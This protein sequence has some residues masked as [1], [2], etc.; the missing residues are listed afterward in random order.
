[1]GERC[2]LCEAQGYIHMDRHWMCREHYN[3]EEAM[4]PD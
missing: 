1:M 3:L 2:Y 4:E